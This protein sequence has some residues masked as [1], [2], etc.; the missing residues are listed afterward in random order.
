M[1]DGPVHGDLDSWGEVHERYR[2]RCNENA[3]RLR[4]IPSCF[5]YARLQATT[6]NVDL[7]PHA[8][9]PIQLPR[10]RRAQSLNQCL[11]TTRSHL[12]RLILRWQPNKTPGYPSARSPGALSHDRVTRLASS[13]RAQYP[14]TK[15][16]VTKL[17]FVRRETLQILKIDID[18]V[19]KL[20]PSELAYR[21]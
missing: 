6:P 19:P 21:E 3:T 20:E 10:D 8:C 15:Y 9:F 18:Q 7:M 2:P 1:D 5:L 14:K 4:E 12:M 16:R 11:M 17:I 13:R